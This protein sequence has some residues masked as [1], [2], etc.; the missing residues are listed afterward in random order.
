MTQLYNLHIMLEYKLYFMQVSV[1][2]CARSQTDGE[3]REG[4]PPPTVSLSQKHLKKRESCTS[5][6]QLQILRQIINFVIL[7]AD[8]L[9]ICS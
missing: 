2:V 6:Q 7:I 1:C 8:S 5:F 3:G 4:P 9:L